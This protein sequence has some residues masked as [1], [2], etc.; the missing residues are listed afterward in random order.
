MMSSEQ[1]IKFAMLAPTYMI[2]AAAAKYEGGAH[3]IAEKISKRIATLIEHTPES[4]NDSTGAR[5][6]VVAAL[7]EALEI[8]KGTKQL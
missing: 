2:A 6:V 7:E 1:F 4:E 3:E 8:A 5:Q